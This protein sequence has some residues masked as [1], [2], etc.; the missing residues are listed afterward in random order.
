MYYGIVIYGILR[1]GQIPSKTNTNCIIYLLYFCPFL[2]W[3]GYIS[4]K[5]HLLYHIYSQGNFSREFV[6]I[7]FIAIRIAPW[8][9]SSTRTPIKFFPG[10]L[11]CYCSHCCMWDIYWEPEN[12]N[13]QGLDHIRKQNYNPKLLATF[14]KKLTLLSTINIPGNP[15]PSNQ[16][17]DDV[18][19]LTLVTI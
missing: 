17:L 10:Q 7:V 4:V 11:E 5:N 16:T 15:P 12:T 13:W 3:C 8:G 14:S 6:Y 19:L 9:C 2:S 1:G 18:I